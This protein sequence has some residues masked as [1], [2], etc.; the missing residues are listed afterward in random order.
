MLTKKCFIDLLYLL[1]FWFPREPA[2]VAVER[3]AELTTPPAAEPATSRRCQA[4]GRGRGQAGGRVRALS[5]MDRTRQS[6]YR[7]SGTKISEED[8]IFV[9]SLEPPP[10]IMHSIFHNYA[11]P[12]FNDT[13]TTYAQRNLIRNPRNDSCFYLPFP[14]IELFKRLPIYSLPLAWNN[15]GD[16]R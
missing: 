1:L 3:V 8:Q 13:W 9:L 5:L 6:R 16:L 11:P 15:L 2:V 10:Q 14:R 12:S 7:T 4:S